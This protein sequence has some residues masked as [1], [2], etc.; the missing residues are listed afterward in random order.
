M[1]K[2]CTNKVE[3]DIFIYIVIDYL[4]NFW[5]TNGVFEIAN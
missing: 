1:K 4:Y 2:Q 5:E 3:T